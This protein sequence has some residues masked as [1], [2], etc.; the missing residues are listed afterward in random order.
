[1]IFSNNR[2]TVGFEYE[3][4]RFI[5]IFQF[6]FL[7]IIATSGIF[8]SCKKFIKVGSPDTSI[9]GES[10]FQTDA[11]AISAITSIY[12]RLSNEQPG[13]I[14]FANISTWIAGLSAD[15][16]SLWTGATNTTWIGYYQ[17][18]L[19][20]ANSIGTQV[21][22]EG[23]KYLFT[24]NAA[25]E[26]LE[27]SS[28]LTT[29]IKKQLLG[30]AK[31]M[32]AFFFFYL[33]NLYGEVPLVLSAKYETISL[34][35]RSSIAAVYKQVVLD[36]KEAKELLSDSYLDANL[37][38]VTDERVR[39]TKSAASAMLARVYLFMEDWVNAETM[40]N[41]LISNS[42]YQLLSP[43]SVF[44]KNSREAIWQLQ[45]TFSG[46]NTQHA[47][48]LVLA[49]T[50]P[51]N[52][53]PIYLSSKLINSFELNDLRKTNWTASVTVSSITYPYAYKYKVSQ[54]N[55]NITSASLMTE[56]LN[57]FR[58][59]E[60]YLIRAEARARQGKFQQSVDDINTLRLQHGG[61]STPLTA[62]AS[63]SPALTVI[64]RE[65]LVELFSEW[66]HRWL[67]LKRS[68][69]IDSVM[70]T[71]TPLKGGIWSPYKQLFPIYEDEIRKNPNLIQNP[72]Y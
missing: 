51:S 56:Y 72:G 70:T 67:D 61:L 18:D 63:L 24:C 30:E 27:K 54:L 22:T 14:S 55:N 1:M 69:T 39:P 34:L 60:Q 8:C 4:Y 42:N 2:K 65:R 12:T 25:I 29:S 57:V 53:N 46:Y 5:K 62:P 16:F 40:A 50:G 35:S 36:L 11:T 19:S 7:I 21:W 66:G 43:N 45:P 3:T 49:S 71:T 28:L 15:E 59:G 9:T 44:L 33:V 31:F 17:N 37:T 10:A 68:G 23:Y 13:S 58:L 26:G 52:T 6:N 20:A 48:L 32:R 41:T 47:R 64:Q 38:K